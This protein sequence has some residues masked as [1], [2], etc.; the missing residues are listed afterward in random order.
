MLR[1]VSVY[2]F[3]LARYHFFR[4]LHHGFLPFVYDPEL[5]AQLN[6]ETVDPEFK[7]LLIVT[8]DPYVPA[9]IRNQPSTKNTALEIMVMYQ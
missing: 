6:G 3:H 1:S 9:I 7:E 2:V 5:S 4:L 8:T